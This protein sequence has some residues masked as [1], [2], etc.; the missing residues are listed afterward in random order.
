MDKGQ[1][2]TAGRQKIL[3]F[4]RKSSSPQIAPTT[5]RSCNL[6]AG[7]LWSRVIQ[8]TFLLIR[9]GYF[10][11]VV[12]APLRT[13]SWCRWRPLVHC[14]RQA[15]LGPDVYF[16]FMSSNSSTGK[17]KAQELISSSV[18]SSRIWN[19]F[20]V[21]DWERRRRNKAKNTL[22]EV[23]KRTVKGVNAPIASFNK[24]VVAGGVLLLRKVEE[25][26]F[27]VISGFSLLSNDCI[28]SVHRKSIR[29]KSR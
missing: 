4:E 1:G 8:R 23:K 28:Y 29:H 25:K 2:S 13:H 22:F 9:G 5:C 24:P 12:L 6:W 3:G 11:S 20:G 16:C 18:P 19:A 10:G 26:V 7:G 21:Q 17:H 14:A 27:S 15:A